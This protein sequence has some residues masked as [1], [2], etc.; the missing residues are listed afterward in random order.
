MRKN[1][2]FEQIALK[3][4]GNILLMSMKSIAFFLIFHE[5]QMSK[6]EKKQHMKTNCD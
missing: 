6:L 4:L 2:K 3:K 1:V 5:K